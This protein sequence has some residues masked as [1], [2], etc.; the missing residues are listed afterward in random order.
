MK[1]NAGATL[2]FGE[3][4]LLIE[5]KCRD[6]GITFFRGTLD[7]KNTCLAMSRLSNANMKMSEVLGLE[8]VGKKLVVGTAEFKISDKSIYSGRK[9]LAV[10]VFEE[11]LKDSDVIFDKYFSSQDSFFH[12]GEEVWARASTRKWVD[13]DE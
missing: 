4:G 8:N 11:K 9:D 6:S 1:I 13:L 10:K 5:L 3:D 7:Q 12:N 2:L